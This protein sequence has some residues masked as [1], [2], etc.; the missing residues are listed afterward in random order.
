MKFL[1][2]RSASKEDKIIEM[3]CAPERVNSGV[4]FDKYEP[5]FLT[6]RSKRNPA[7]IRITCRIK[8]TATADNGFLLGTYFWGSF[9]EKNGVTVLRGHIATA[10]IYHAALLMLLAFFIYRCI[11]LSAFNPTPVILV[12]FDAVLFWR[13][14]KKRGMIERYIRR[15]IR[16]LDDGQL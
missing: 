4:K 16:R 15:T 14:F 8:N 13:E 9:K 7:R 11:T 6:K 3:L 1:K 12:A 2:F 10:P 5:D